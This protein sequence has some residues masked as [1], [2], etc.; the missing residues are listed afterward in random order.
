MPV[1]KYFCALLVPIMMVG[2]AF[3]EQRPAPNIA[4]TPPYWQP[5]NQLAELR[6]FHEKE[7][8]K[9]SDEMHVVRNR[10]MERLE[11]AAKDLEREQR[12]QESYEKTVERREKWGSWFKRGNKGG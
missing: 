10:E 8:A 12:W 11:A 6:A 1:R 7:S 9:M 2:C 3:L 5:Q 4:N